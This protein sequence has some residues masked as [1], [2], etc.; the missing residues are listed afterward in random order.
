ML[1]LALGAPG[2]DVI[3]GRPDGRA[4]VVVLELG[5]VGHLAQGRRHVELVVREAGLDV[6]EAGVGRVDP[7]RQISDDAVLVSH[8]AHDLPEAGLEKGGASAHTGVDAGVELAASLVGFLQG[9]ETDRR[10]AGD[11][12]D[13][14]S[15]PVAGSHVV[16][17]LLAVGVAERRVGLG[18]GPGPALLDSERRQGLVPALLELGHTLGLD[19]V[20]GRLGLRLHLVELRLGG[21]AAVPGLGFGRVARGHEPEDLGLL[22]DREE[23]AALDVRDGQG[24]GDAATEGDED[25]G[26]QDG[27]QL[28]VHGLPPSLGFLEPFRGNEALVG[29]SL[30]SE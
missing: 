3:G 8:L 30:L 29:A 1:L 22:L 5:L 16:D 4:D 27:D 28:A 9:Q 18:Q 13:L 14:V 7:G 6:V 26:E 10:R 21:V 25:Q 23:R 17:Q 11:V 20:G 19:F 12:L 15:Q 2:G 24:A